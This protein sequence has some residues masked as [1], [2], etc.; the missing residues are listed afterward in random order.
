[1]ELENCEEPATFKS[2]VKKSVE[3]GSSPP[4]DVRVSGVTIH[5]TGPHR[6]TPDPHRTAPGRK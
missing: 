3:T 1:M 4:N 6:A 5:R 2:L